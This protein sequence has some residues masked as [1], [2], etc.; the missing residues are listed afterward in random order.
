MVDSGGS[1]VVSSGGFA[2]P[3]IIHGG[4]SETVSSGGTDDG[5]LISGGTQFDY[6]FAS[7]VTIFTGLQVVDFGG[8][9]SGTILSGGT[10][11]IDAGT[12]VLGTGVASGSIVFSSGGTLEIAGS[13]MPTAV[14]SGF[15]SGDVIDLASV[16][17]IGSFQHRQYTPSA[18]RTSAPAGHPA[19]GPRGHAGGSAVLSSGNVLPGFERFLLRVHRPTGG[20]ATTRIACTVGTSRNKKGKEVDNSATSGLAAL[21]GR[22][23][24]PI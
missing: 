20:S 15:T 5:A 8:T 10:L 24:Y 14:I 1:L 22:C 16:A 9:A 13:A 18:A 4:G 17:G 6:G 23:H 21:T 2:D 12:A 3:T 19:T 7:G 11:V